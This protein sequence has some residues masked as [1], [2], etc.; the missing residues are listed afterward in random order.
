MFS[1]FHNHALSKNLPFGQQYLPWQNSIQLTARLLLAANVS[2]FDVFLPNSPN[3]WYFP[4]EKRGKSD[5][6]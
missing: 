4:L 5:K 6:T 3:E 2:L 1:G